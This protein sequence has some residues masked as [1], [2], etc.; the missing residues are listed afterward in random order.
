MSLGGRSGSIAFADLGVHRLDPVEHGVLHC[1]DGSAEIQP[2]S[3]AAH[4]RHK[5]LPN[6]APSQRPLADWA[7]SAV[8][9]HL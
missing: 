4:H 5:V 2:L 3:P 7:H 1:H 6:H 9:R 8:G